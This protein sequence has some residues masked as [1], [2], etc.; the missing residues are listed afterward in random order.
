MVNSISN[1]ADEIRANRLRDAALGYRLFAAY[2]WGDMG[3]G[4]ISARDPERSDCFWLLRSGVS[5]HN[6]TVSDLVLVGPDGA[7]VH[8]NGP[9]NK[10]AYYIHQPIHDAR[11]EVSSAVHVH[12]DWGTPFAAEARPLQPISQESCIF[13]ENHALFDDEEVQVQDTGGGRRIAT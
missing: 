7:V 8:G 9:I 3:D 4:H 6:A 5:F 1:S 12:T 13:F 10:S 2:G 11:P